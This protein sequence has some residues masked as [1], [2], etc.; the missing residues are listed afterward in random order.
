VRVTSPS[1]PLSLQVK[2]LQKNNGF[3][4]S[5]N[6]MDDGRVQL[7]VTGDKEDN[8]VLSAKQGDDIRNP[9][10]ND[11]LS[12]LRAGTW[13][14]YVKDDRGCSLDTFVTLDEPETLQ[15][16]VDSVRH[17]Q[18]Y[19][20][21]MGVVW[22][23]VVGGVSPYVYEY[24]KRHG[25]WQDNS[26][27]TGL[28]ADDNMSFTV[29][30][31]GNCLAF[32][33][34]SLHDV[35]KRPITI[36]DSVVH[37]TCHTV[38]NGLY[39]FRPIGDLR[40][41]KYMWDGDVVSDTVIE[42]VAAGIHVLRVEDEGGCYYSHSV[43]VRPPDVLQVQL[44]SYDSLLRCFG[45][46]NG[47]VKLSAQGGSGQYQW[48]LQRVDSL[49]YPLLVAERQAQGGIATFDSLPANYYQISLSDTKCTTDERDTII[50]HV[51]QPT[52][53]TVTSQV[54]N[55]ACYGES[56]GSIKLEVSGGVEPYTY[57]DYYGN[58]SSGN[59]DNLPAG[60]YSYIIQDANECP[61]ETGQLMVQPAMPLLPRPQP[62]FLV[63]TFNLMG[64]T[65]MLVEH[66]QP[67]P[68]SVRWYVSGDAD[69]YLDEDR[70]FLLMQQDGEVLVR[71]VAYYQGCGFDTIKLI[72]AYESDTLLYDY[73]GKGVQPQIVSMWLSPNPMRRDIKLK[74]TLSTPQTL[75]LLVRDIMGNTVFRKQY[76][77]EGEYMEDDLQLPATGTRHLYFTLYTTHDIKTQK[78]LQQDS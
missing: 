21:S 77:P 47:K 37:A 70:P 61:V 75:N 65:L 73:R 64:D 74:V 17:N 76:N 55:V 58:E 3:D 49:Q 28:H 63:S 57:T 13:L 27:F 43:K 51:A 60:P 78:I 62:A 24:D 46:E 32:A 33:D 14:F 19:Q 22:L 12:N 42:S 11:T 25:N 18:C 48:T 10:L 6:G 5:C 26:I 4:I 9:L 29:R 41:T 67:K 45:F 52:R 71:M 72:K 7:T 66:S 34:T 30:D 56:S 38:A 31:V 39:F 54:S 44:I 36:E 23:H 59:N 35:S 20:D 16:Y 1:V 68:D 15:L 53:M 50:I 40:F 8:P 2:K 69:Y